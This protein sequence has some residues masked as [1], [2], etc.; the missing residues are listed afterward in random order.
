MKSS[1]IIEGAI[2][3]LPNEDAWSPHG[4]SGDSGETRC[5]LHAMAAVLHRDK[6]GRLPHAGELFVL[7]ISAHEYEE[8]RA[9][10]EAGINAVHEGFTAGIGTFNDTHSY[11]DVMLALKHG[12][13]IAQEG[14]TE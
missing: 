10:V 5:M 7:T 4:W 11:E 3:L 14:N 8:A 1:D 12:L 9:D 13:A 6:V 2:E